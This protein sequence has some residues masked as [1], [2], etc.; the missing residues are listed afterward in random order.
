[1]LEPADASAAIGRPLPFALA[2]LFHALGF[3]ALAAEAA[4]TCRRGQ[5][6]SLMLLEHQVRPNPAGTHWVSA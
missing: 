3:G 6:C 5:P 4:I 1:M 2:R